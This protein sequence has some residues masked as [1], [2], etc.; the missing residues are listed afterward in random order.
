M[1]LSVPSLRRTIEGL[2]DK[3]ALE[4]D[5]GANVAFD[6]AFNELVRY[7]IFLL[8]ISTTIGEAGEIESYAEVPGGWLRSPHQTWVS[9]YRRLFSK[10]ADKLTDDSEFVKDL[11]YVP[12]K[13]LTSD[14]KLSSN[15]INGII[16]LGAIYAHR[17]EAWVTKRTIVENREGDE[18]S[19]RLTLTGSDQKAYEDVV[20]QF[21]GAWE[22]VLACF[23]RLY[24]WR[25]TNAAK[26]DLRWSAL[27]KSWPAI[28]RHLTNTAYILSIAVWNEDVSASTHYQDA[29]LKWFGNFEHELNG[30]PIGLND[31]LVIPNTLNMTWEE[32]EK[33]YFASAPNFVNHSPDDLFRIVLT[34][35]HNDVVL[36]IAALHLYW[37]INDKQATRLSAEISGALLRREFGVGEASPS[38]R[39]RIQSRGFSD[40]FKDIV[41]QQLA[42]TW[43][44]DESYGA[45]L[46]ELV[47]SS[48]SM[49]ERRVVPGRTYTPTT[50]HERND[51]SVVIT[52]IMIHTIPDSNPAK[53]NKW[54]QSLADNPSTLPNFDKSL[55]NLIDFF[56][57]TIGYLSDSDIRPFIDKGAKAL[58]AEDDSIAVSC[59]RLTT[60]LSDAIRI[61]ERAREQRLREAPVSNRRLDELRADAEKEIFQLKD[62]IPF[63]A[64]F[65]IKPS[66]EKTEAEPYKLIFG[67]HSKGIFV[68][69]PMAEEVGNFSE[70]LS[71]G[72][73]DNASRRVWQMFTQRSRIKIETESEFISEDFW[74]L[75]AERARLVGGDP[76]LVV[77]HKQEGET[78][79]EMVHQG[80]A[81][82]NIE[83]KQPDIVRNSYVATV[84][85]IDVYSASFPAGTAWLF[86]Q[87]ALKEII[88]FPLKLNPIH[89]VEV[90]FEESDGVGQLSMTYFLSA[91]WIDQTIIEFNLNT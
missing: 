79:W 46:D 91:K 53:L 26:A 90:D 44:R 37:F 59:D 1:K 78:L 20:L 61:I 43:H 6:N 75:I 47:R 84:E 34:N 11:A 55:R 28:W 36:I 22:N 74:D 14:L 86:S 17:L 38:E 18:P 4:I 81:D 35:A 24:D 67:E 82:L 3:V 41:R 8:S 83:R 13:I 80:S 89:F 27:S 62:R 69:P 65:D 66:R 16:D 63:F 54:I 23:P 51:L 56:V 60:V 7:H 31:E 85:G 10:A 12:Y 57:R 45:M 30:Y 5:N 64:D 73:A 58:G 9:Q 87:K 25:T 72:L 42:G 29:L 49:T 76:I 32:A 39:A 33:E 21:I 68:D 40:L 2:A 48:D 88:F 71:S 19:D 77:S 50:L 70:W 15:V 52:I